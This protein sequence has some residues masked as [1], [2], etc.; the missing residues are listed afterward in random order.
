MKTLYT[1]L[2]LLLTLTA[3]AQTDSVRTE[4]R[5]EDAA[6]S[7]SEL[8]R[9]IRYITR[10]DVEE[11]T[12]IKLGFWP[13]FN[14]RTGSNRPAFS[15]GFNAETSIERKLSP[16]FS[17]YVGANY[18]LSYASYERILSNAPVSPPS[19]TRPIEATDNQRNFALVG[20]VGVRYYYAMAG[21][22]RRGTSA[23]NFSG[24][25]ISFQAERFYSDTHRSVY[26]DIA[27]GDSRVYLD[28]YINIRP[29]F[30]TFWGFQRRLGRLGY[31]DLS[32]GPAFR[33]PVD[34]PSFI[35][36]FYKQYPTG[37]S[38]SLQINALIGLG[39]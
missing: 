16:A 34:P 26:Y 3:H 8:Q 32:A 27:T 5:T 19:G 25:Y 28:R 17:V 31:I 9:F 2:A 22:A 24:N 21:K 39:W 1:T 15:V 35:L 20:K 30:S 23:N 14:G 36:P 33:L 38:L 12:L 10:A 37:K 29:V 7:K 6:V 11:K 13:G 4:Y 18:S